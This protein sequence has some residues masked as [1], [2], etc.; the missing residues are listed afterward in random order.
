MEEWRVIP[1][2]GY[3][4]MVSNEGRVKRAECIIPYANGSMRHNSERMMSPS[5]NKRIGRWYITI[6]Q[7]GERPKNHL[8]HRLVA[9]AFCDNDDPI[10]KTTV[11]HIDGNPS[12]N[13]ATNLEWA[14]FG[15]NL[16]H[17]YNTLGRVVNRAGCTKHP[18]VVTNRSDGSRQEFESI[19]SCSRGIGLS[20]TQVRRIIDGESTNT[21]YIIQN[22][23]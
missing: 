5:Y 16:F 13:H 23:T 7:H 14:S 17:A 12:N 21:Q 10:H 19:E 11:N 1:S 22:I 15:E 8:L 3:P 20:P 18:C 4:Y 9:E 2:I 6:N